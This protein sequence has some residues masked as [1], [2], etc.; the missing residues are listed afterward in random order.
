MQLTAPML[1]LP[2][3]QLPTV[4]DARDLLRSA[5]EWLPIGV[6]VVN[7]DGVI[8]VVNREVE[9]LFGYADGELIG[10]SIDVLVPD[11]ARTS[12]AALR[13]DFTAQPHPR[14]M[15][16]GRELFG[17]RKD[18]SEVPVEVGLTPIRLNGSAFVLA[19]VIDLTE[20]RRAQIALDERLTFERFVGELGAEFV[21][22]R[23]EEV[24]RALQDALG[25]VVRTLGLDRSA[26]FQVDDS[27][28]FVHTHQSTRPGCS[29]VAASCLGAPGISLASVPDS[30]PGRWSASLRSTTF[31]TPS[32]ARAFVVSARSRPSRSRSASRARRGGPSVSALC[33]SRGRGRPM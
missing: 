4:A 9:R 14:A 20:R 26:L 12:H 18:G 32:I 8:A 3:E 6:L 10:Q 29:A 7:G 23:P 28:D 15:G 25:R 30:Q 16:A 33:E 27:G 11:V 1:E 13:R 24:D 21:N 19:S 22:L 31:L 17:R 2:V 5:I